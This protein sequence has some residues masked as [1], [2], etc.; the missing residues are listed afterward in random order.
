MKNRIVPVSRFLWIFAGPILWFAHFAAMYGAEA[1]ICTGAQ[2]PRSFRSVAIGL[3]LVAI[4]ALA[5]FIIRTAR[6]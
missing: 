2:G 6:T 5:V 4:A 3:T 1:L